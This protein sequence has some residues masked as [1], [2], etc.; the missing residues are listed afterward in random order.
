MMAVADNFKKK[1]RKKLELTT[2]TEVCIHV[3]TVMEK[4]SILSFN[5]KALHIR[6]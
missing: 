3:H 1:N 5:F 2:N 4:E 6:T